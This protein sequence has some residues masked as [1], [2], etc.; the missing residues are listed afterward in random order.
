MVLHGQG[1]NIVNRQNG[2]EV[3]R[4]FVALNDLADDGKKNNSL[5]EKAETPEAKSQYR[6]TLTTYTSAGRPLVQYYKVD[7]LGHAYSSY[8][9]TEFFTDGI[10]ASG[11]IAGS[12]SS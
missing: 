9:L 4:Q 7:K 8:V 11:G 10:D 5:R 1:D 12:T 6:Y 3:V 2:D